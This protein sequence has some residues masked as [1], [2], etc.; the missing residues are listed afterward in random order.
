M[1]KKCRED[2]KVRKT[3]RKLKNIEMTFGLFR[4]S[5]YSLKK[6]TR[7]MANGLNLKS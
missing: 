7:L 4:L 2:G 6:A 3:E 5:I 1:L